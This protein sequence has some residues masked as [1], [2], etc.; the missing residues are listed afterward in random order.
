MYSHSK[1]LVTATGAGVLC[2]YLYY[3]FQL[4]RSWPNL[5]RTMKRTLWVSL[6]PALFV[7]SRIVSMWR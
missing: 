4:T 7:T 3:A 5:S 2:F 1:L 6:L